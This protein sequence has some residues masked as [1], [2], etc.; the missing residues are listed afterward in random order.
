[1]VTICWEQAILVFSSV[2]VPYALQTLSPTVAILHD[3]TDT[4]V[5]DRDACIE[6]LASSLTRDLKALGRH[7]ETVTHQINVSERSPIC[8]AE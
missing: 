4:C 8:V 2:P 5:S 3:L 1:M 6:R 7:V